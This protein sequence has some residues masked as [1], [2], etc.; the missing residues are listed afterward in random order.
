MQGANDNNGITETKKWE[1][2]RKAS[3]Y[4]E[5]AR[6]NKDRKK[7]NSDGDE[8]KP[9]HEVIKG[10]SEKG[11]GIEE[12]EYN[13]V[14]GKQAI[15]I[16]K[17]DDDKKA[18]YSEDLKKADE[19][20]L[21][22]LL[23]SYNPAEMTKKIDSLH[24][25]V[26]PL[27]GRLEKKIEALKIKDPNDKKIGELQKEFD[28][29][30]KKKEL[31]EEEKKKKEEYD[32][33][34]AKLRAIYNGMLTE[35]HFEKDKDLRH[36]SIL[37]KGEFLNDDKNEYTINGLDGKKSAKEVLQSISGLVDE[38]DALA[39]KLK[40]NSS[41]QESQ[42]KHDE[43]VQKID[44]IT[45]DNNAKQLVKEYV[46]KA[47]GVTLPDD[48]KME[49]MKKENGFLVINIAENNPS[50]EKG[51]E[52]SQDVIDKITAVNSRLQ[53]TK[54]K[55]QAKKEIDQIESNI[56]KLDE[57]FRKVIEDIEYKKKSVNN[58]QWKGK[59]FGWMR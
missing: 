23:S 8:L 44:N 41:D 47:Y 33:M 35:K 57:G 30:N 28:E 20:V 21:E 56:K 43:V 55:E 40:Q 14:L 22:T 37:L 18:E 11:E 49:S 45:N 32:E 48:F 51:K 31:L 53:T 6:I 46:Q 13:K 17:N 38:R 50:K 29:L 59:F 2:I 26:H 42:T 25:E 39:E 34:I 54:E 24:K 1:E 52:I 19:K 27:L 16:K 10:I 9:I 58:P 15:D 4:Y 7:V 3:K 12:V 5:R 36:A